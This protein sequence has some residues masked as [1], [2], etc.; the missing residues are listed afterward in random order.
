M[1]ILF[2]EDEVNLSALGADQLRRLG[3]QVWEAPNLQVAR[4]ILDDLTINIQLIIADHRLPDGF[5][6]DFIIE[7]AKEES[8]PIPA[9]IVSGCLTPADIAILNRLDIPY[10]R[11]PVLYSHVIRKMQQTTPVRKHSGPA[12]GGTG[13]EEDD[14][15]GEEAV[16]VGRAGWFRGIVD[17]FLR[18]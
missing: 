10:F 8:L 13:E 7:E 9:V 5:G 15:L 1:R 14:G 18:P 2:I 17:R 3:H 6:I 16:G 11:K 12:A 4:A